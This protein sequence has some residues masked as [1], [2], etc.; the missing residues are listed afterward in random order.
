[1]VPLL[2]RPLISPH[3]T[4]ITLFI[5]TVLEAQIGF[6]QEVPPLTDMPTP[7]RVLSYLPL[8]E[9]P[10]SQYDPKI[11]KLRLADDK[12]RIFDNIFDL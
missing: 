11:I 8:P 12:L 9:T 6:Q 7:H 1:M 2:Q 4:L 5:N 10:L 3:A